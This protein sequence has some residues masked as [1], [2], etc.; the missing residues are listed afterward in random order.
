MNT[1]AST[2]PADFLLPLGTEAMECRPAGALPTGTGWQYEPK[3]DGFR[4]LAFKRGSRVELRAK[5]GKPLGRYFPELVARL[6]ASDL[7][8]VV[9][10]GEILVPV[11]GAP[12]FP[13]LQARVHPAA[14]RIRTLSVDT[15]A[16]LVVFDCLAT[17]GDGSLLERP[18]SEWRR[19]LE[20]L[21]A[22]GA[23]P[24]RLSPVATDLGIAD[25]WLRRMGAAI[26]GIV[27]KRADDPYAPGK[28]ATLKVKTHRT[29][30][31]VVGGF[32]YAA[33][34]REVGSLLLGLFNE[35]G[36]L[37]H[38]GFTSAIARAERPALTRRL[39]ALRGGEGFSGKAPG[40]PSRWSNA[41][42]AE[43]ERL[44]PALVVEVSFDGVT[45]GRLRHGAMLKRWRPDK[46][47][48]Q[49]RSEQIAPVLDGSTTGILEALLG[50]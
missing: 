17:A 15:P 29:I 46:A 26:D 27:A 23:P 22:A 13:A 18:L 5:S 39:E 37:D 4:C 28:R 25:E 33:G 2:G 32:R 36:L 14:S 48:L 34:T 7:D 16:L 40:G 3:W 11:G 35:A 24:F 47:P 30:D 50:S 38:V 6:S 43:W 9:L 41:R 42:S 49:C 8:D 21:A 10:D 20:R 45:D 31:C 19:V 12:S 1:D 44:R